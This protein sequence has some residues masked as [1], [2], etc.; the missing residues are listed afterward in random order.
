MAQ[1]CLYQRSK[2]K[3]VTNH[4]CIRCGKKGHSPKECHFV[5]A[6]CH[7][8]NKKGHIQ[9]ACLAKKKNQQSINTISS[10]TIQTVKAINAIP[11]VEQAVLVD[12]K[13]FTFEV[14]TGAGENF[15]SRNNWIEL[16]KPP[17]QQ[18]DESFQSASG[19][20]LPVLGVYS[21]QNVTFINDEKKS[22]SDDCK[23]RFITATSFIVRF[24][25]RFKVD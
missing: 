13:P 23:V 1:R 6:V 10:E 18:V 17:L 25:V 12:G 9:S 2:S 5:N 24:I 8:C 15:R 19:H 20:K 16:G 22:S 21:P 4:I 7:Y 11:Y 3:Q 14:D